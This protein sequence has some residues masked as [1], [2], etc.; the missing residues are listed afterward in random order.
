MIFWISDSDLLVL[1]TTMH[2]FN[3]TAYKTYVT[4]N[5]TLTWIR[6][7]LATLSTASGQDWVEY[8][9]KNNSGTYNNEYIVLDSK[10]FEYQVKPTK[11]LVWIIEQMPGYYHASDITTDFVKKGYWPSVNT[12]FFID[13]FNYSD[14]PGQQDREPKKKNF[15]SYFD[16]PRFKI[17]ER[18][19]PKIHSYEDFQKFMRYNNYKND[20]LILNEPAQGI[21]ARY[22][23]RPPNGTDF[24]AQRV[25]GGLDSKTVKMSDALNLLR[26]DAI[27][28]PEYI[29]NTPFN[30]SFWEN[31]VTNYHLPDV[32][33]FNWTSF[34]TGY[35]RCSQFN[36]ED[37]CINAL[38]CG[39]CIMI[40][41]VYLEVINLIH[42]MVFYVKMDGYLKFHFH[43]ML[44][45][46]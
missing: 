27:N 34:E 37:N 19:A 33:K 41:F 13:V 46:W 38:F 40:K 4:P 31:N 9:I 16:Q 15:W 44:F 22:D 30:F 35:N 7:Y 26:F 28:S 36:N 32:W 1:E 43:L 14:Y 6:S 5:S 20:P 17:I 3:E 8:F 21:L 45:L 12:P 42:M 39:W 11:D 24:G 29:F 2:N 25:F 23:L 10:K 18:D